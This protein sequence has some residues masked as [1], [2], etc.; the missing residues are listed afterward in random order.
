[1]SFS[2]STRGPTRPIVI[3]AKANLASAKAHMVRTL[4]D[5]K[6]ACDLLPTKAIAQSDYDL[7]KGN[8][9]EAIAAV[10]V[11]EAM[12]NTAELNLGFTKVT[13]PVSGRVSRYIVTVGNMVQ[14]ADQPT[15]PS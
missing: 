10:K 1:M 11:A 2:N 12:V 15:S 6:R 4:A 7:A 5:F 8:Y 13:A 14:S 3:G 9:D